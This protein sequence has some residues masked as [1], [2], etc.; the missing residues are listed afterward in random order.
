VQTPSLVCVCAASAATIL[1]TAVTMRPSVRYAYLL[2][3]YA[4]LPA[5]VKIVL[6]PWA[7]DDA[8][9]QMAAASM[10]NDV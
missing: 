7:D 4:C 10:Y 8:G 1:K 9:R 5:Q 3:M 6:D 2:T